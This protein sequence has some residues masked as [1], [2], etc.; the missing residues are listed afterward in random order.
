MKQGRRLKVSWLIASQKAT[1]LDLSQAQT[2]RGRKRS[3]TERC[4]TIAADR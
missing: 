1:R 3:G 2:Q 4:R